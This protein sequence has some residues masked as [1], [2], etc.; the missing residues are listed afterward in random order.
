M[1][2]T[3]LICTATHFPFRDGGISFTVVCR[4]VRAAL[5]GSP[6][7]GRAVWHRK[8][9][10]AAWE[11]S[12][13]TTPGRINQRSLASVRSRIFLG[14]SGSC[15]RHG[16]QR[17][18]KEGVQPS[19]AQPNQPPACPWGDLS[20]FFFSVQRSHSIPVRNN[21]SLGVTALTEA[22]KK[23]ICAMSICSAVVHAYRLFC[24]RESLPRQRVVAIAYADALRPGLAQR[25]GTVA[26]LGETGED[27]AVMSC[28]V[29]RVDELSAVTL[30]AAPASEHAGDGVCTRL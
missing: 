12:P 9:R 19:P 1:H 29:S 14:G 26:R 3:S 23:Q 13:G 18:A 21:S 5:L 17:D 20:F 2:R 10:N 8:P 11:K 6:K 28:L 4:R 25:R 24:V 22:E 7:G 27:K 30:V 16:R 15:A